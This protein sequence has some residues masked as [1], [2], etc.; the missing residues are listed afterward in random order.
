MTLRAEVAEPF[1]DTG[2][3]VRSST[4]ATR[5]R[6]SRSGPCTRP[7]SREYV[8]T[9]DEWPRLLSL[10]KMRTLVA[11]RGGQIVAYLV[12]SRATNKPGILEAGGTP[13]A[14]EALIATALRDRAAGEDVP[15]GLMRV[16]HV[17]RNGVLDRLGEDGQPVTGGHT[18]VRI[19]DPRAFW[20]ALGE[21]GS[22]PAID[23]R[24]LASAIFGPH[25]ERWVAR[26]ASM[27]ARFPIPLT[28]PPLDHS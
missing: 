23:R 11:R 24:E 14:V 9:A 3:V 7:T 17:L 26:P 2:D 6:S 8:R 15:V 4:S 22:P 10:P 13:L 19:N 12:D 20:R 1:R 5:Q 27:A 16:P 28:I 18:M 25:P 21:P